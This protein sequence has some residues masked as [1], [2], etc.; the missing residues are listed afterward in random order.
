MLR[1]FAMPALVVGALSYL[2]LGYGGY[3]L[4]KPTS[5]SQFE[6]E[7]AF[8]GDIPSQKHAATCYT[9]GHCI[10]FVQAPVIGCAWRQVIVDETGHDPAAE[11]EAEEACRAVS[12]TLSRAVAEAKRDI[13]SRIAQVKLKHHSHHKG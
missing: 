11:R 10:G 2:V 3:R 1:N 5:E 4:L 9:Q 7:H 8:E 12:P 13:E 6:M